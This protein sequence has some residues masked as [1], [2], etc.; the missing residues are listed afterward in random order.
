MRS[1]LQASEAIDLNL[2][3]LAH[4]PK[5]YVHGP[6]DKFVSRT[7]RE[8]GLWEPYETSLVLELL[9]PGDVLVDVG[10][11]IGYFSILAASVVGDSGQVIAFEPDPENY[12]LF[13]ASIKLNEFEERIE[14]CEAGLSVSDSYGNLYL[15]TDNLGDHQIYSGEPGR[16]SLPITLYNGA[17]FLRSRI[18]RLDLLKVD[19]QGSEFAVMQGLMPLLQELH[20]PPQILIELT[21][22]SL[23]E[24]GDSGRA[25]INLLDQLGQP[26]WIIDHLEHRLARSS[27][28]ELVLWCD[29]V[30]ACEGDMG[31]MNI[32][33]GAGTQ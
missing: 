11:N 8:T 23:Q 24:A 13:D 27:A 6:H 15:S 17:D 28:D 18:E 12:A 5:L 32:L 3:T 33:V 16:Q 9:K 20:Q 4:P 10:A 25:L 26:L 22:Y 21:P 19:T 29:N 7:I 2:P 31:F 1:I 14:A 30:D